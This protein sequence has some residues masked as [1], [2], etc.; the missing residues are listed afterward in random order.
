[1]AR[2]WL[3]D[4]HVLRTPQS[5][6]A[7]APTD[8]ATCAPH[9]VTHGQAGTRCEPR[10]LSLLSPPRLFFASSF[11]FLI[12]SSRFFSP[13]T[14]SLPHHFVLFPF[15]LTTAVSY[16]TNSLSLMNQKWVESFNRKTRYNSFAIFCQTSSFTPTDRL[17]V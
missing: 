3:G 17:P 8:G 12:F 7:V 6:P 1:M 9:M 10:C 13:F 15:S 11:C 2:L 16:N 4:G 5:S 14:P